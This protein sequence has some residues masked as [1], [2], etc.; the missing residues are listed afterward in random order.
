MKLLN[1]NENWKLVA[2]ELGNLKDLSREGTVRFPI[3]LLTSV[4]LR[5]LVKS[6]VAEVS[7]PDVIDKSDDELANGFY[8]VRNSSGK[9]DLYSFSSN[10][11][12]NLVLDN[13][14]N[15]D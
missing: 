3:C 15:F 12:W 5:L 6:E 13:L 7:K 8:L 11:T 2:W 14:T 1:E 9:L 10:R 4:L